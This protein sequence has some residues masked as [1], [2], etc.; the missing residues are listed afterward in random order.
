MVCSKSAVQLA[1]PLKYFS[2]S[3]AAAGE[4]AACAAD[5]GAASENAP[6]N[7]KAAAAGTLPAAATIRPASATAQVHG[8]S[9]SDISFLGRRSPIDFAA[10]I[11]LQRAHQACGL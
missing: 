7:I 11:G 4:A 8:D 10:A 1:R 6:M 9:L 5:A 2:T 3:A